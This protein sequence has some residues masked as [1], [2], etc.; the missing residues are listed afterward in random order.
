MTQ[1]YEVTPEHGKVF[2]NGLQIGIY[3]V[4]KWSKQIVLEIGYTKQTV[5]YKDKHIVKRL[6]E[7]IHLGQVERTKRELTKKH[8]LRS[9][10]YNTGKEFKVLG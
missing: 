3:K 6:A 10:I 8:K 2:Y 9:S 1:F 5:D 4:F 7:R